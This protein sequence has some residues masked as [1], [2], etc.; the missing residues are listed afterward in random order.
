ML[1]LEPSMLRLDPSSV[2]FDP[3]MLGFESST[4]V[5]NHDTYEDDGKGI[6][7]FRRTYAVAFSFSANR[8]RIASFGSVA[9]HILRIRTNGW[10]A[11]LVRKYAS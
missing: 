8:A 1:R 10:L 11:A 9:G 2:L 6:H 7:H 3:S 5:S 4:L